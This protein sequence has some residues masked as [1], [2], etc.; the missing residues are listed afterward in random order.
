MR[1]YTTFSNFILAYHGCSQ[2]K[3][4]VVLNNPAR[5]L[6]ES[7]NPYDWLGCG[8]YFWE[9]DPVRAWQ[10]ASENNKK[11]EV[12]YVIGAVIDLG[13]CLNLMNQDSIQLLKEAYGAVSAN[14]K[15]VGRSL[16][17]NKGLRRD[18]DCYVINALY[19]MAEQMK[20]PPY[21]TV[22]AM[23]QEGDPIYPGTEFK[24]KNHIQICVRSLSCIKGYFRTD[25]AQYR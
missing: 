12:P 13:N 11:G 15:V 18:L 20:I 8:I 3:A 22:R 10:W 1:P 23:F 17:D 5:H 16:P 2:E 4:D 14:I 25:P 21:D 19:V 24:S 9:N 6:P 7:H